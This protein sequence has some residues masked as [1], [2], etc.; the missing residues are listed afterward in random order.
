[1]SST[2][3]SRVSLQIYQDPNEDSQS[4]NL[5]TQDPTAL[6]NPSPFHPMNELSSTRAK[7]TFSP[8]QTAVS[9]KKSPQKAACQSSISP[10]RIPFSNKLNM[11]SM[12]PPG[13]RS[14]NT[15]SMTKKQPAIS[16]LKPHKALF[17]TFPINASGENIVYHHSETPSLHQNEPLASLYHHKVITCTNFSLE[18]LYPDPTPSRK[19]LLEAAPIH[20]RKICKKLKNQNSRLNS[21]ENYELPAPDSFPP[22]HD[23]GS[24]P[25][26][27]YAQLIGMSILRAP[28]RRLTLAQIYKWI[29]DSFKF[30][31]ATDAGWQNS[32]RHN[33]S[34]NKAFLKQERP[35]DD[36]GK[37]NYWVIKPGME[38]QFIKERPPSRKTTE[39][40]EHTPV[41]LAAE[42]QSTCEEQ[43]LPLN[44]EPILNLPQSSGSGRF[45]ND[46]NS[47]LDQISSDATI[48]NSDSIDPQIEEDSLEL[49][50]YSPIL[51]SSP[52]SATMRSS[53]PI[54][55]QTFKDTPPSMPHI[56][57]PSQD[58]THKRKLASMDDSGY[59]SS[60]DSSVMRGVSSRSFHCDTDLT[61]IKHGRAE[62]E[63]ARLRGSSCD[64]PTKQRQIYSQ[65]ASSPTRRD[66]KLD[67]PQLLPPLTPAIKLHAPARAPPSASPNTN[68]RL[69]RDRVREMVGS[70]L[71][72]M[73]TLEESF[74]WSPASNLDE[75]SYMFSTALDINADFDVFNDNPS[76]IGIPETG[77]P[78]RKI[79]KRSSQDRCNLSDTSHMA[80]GKSLASTPPVKFSLG[81]S[82]SISESP[83]KSLDV[84]PYQ[85]LHHFPDSPTKYDKHKSHAPAIKIFNSLQNDDK[86]NDIFSEDKE[87]SWDILQGFQKIGTSTKCLTGRLCENSPSN[88]RPSLGRSYTTRF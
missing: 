23:D 80:F 66:L 51:H 70:P 65:Q 31:S 16:K 26:H 81:L 40:H 55:C 33:L 10:S 73:T 64:S 15:D 7:I 27:S 6:R 28:S 84:S 37:G 1:M 17:T 43:Q 47:G 42:S 29:S 57:S 24:K 2:N 36:P 30:Y 44:I 68:L 77:S 54:Q 14:Y 61:K 52:P 85:N 83:T 4:P 76:N 49:E 25:P 88:V 35:K 63:I 18:G 53:P 20:E 39:Y 58:R 5:K 72:G 50:P 21:N 62:Q 11:V 45:Q 48:P 13:N 41:P 74:P 67:V 38:F 69:H 12:P 87:E 9:C 22:L 46:Q 34:L 78:E 71:R 59:Y 56:Q 60:L 32:I 3:R 8:P 75:S 82:P 79:A 19:R 86:N